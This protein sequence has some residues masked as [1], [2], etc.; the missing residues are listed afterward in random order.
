MLRFTILLCVLRW[1]CLHFY[2]IGRCTFLCVSLRYVRSYAIFIA[3]LFRQC[4]CTYVCSFKK[5]YETTCSRP[6]YDVFAYWALLLLLYQ[7]QIPRS[8]QASLLLGKSDARMK[9]KER[10]TQHT[11][12][13]SN[14]KQKINR[15][16]SSL[17]LCW[18]AKLSLKPHTISVQFHFTF[19]TINIAFASL[20]S[21]RVCVVLHNVVRLFSQWWYCSIFWSCAQFELIV[22]VLEIKQTSNGIHTFHL[23]RSS[24]RKKR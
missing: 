21:C 15:M 13:L 9:E 6:S 17:S 1:P 18:Q 4:V 12:T 10:Y 14:G 8:F 7:Y 16:C 3:I 20:S 5:E 2:H 23:K 22:P 19:R 11:Q 24:E